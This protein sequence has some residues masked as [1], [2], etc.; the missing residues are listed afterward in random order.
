MKVIQSSMEGT[1]S[2]ISSFIAHFFWQPPDI[3]HL[4]DFFLRLARPFPMNGKFYSNCFVHFE[5]SSPID[6][7][8]RYDPMLDIPPY[9]IPNSYWHKIWQEEHPE[10]W[11][12]VSQA[13]K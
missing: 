2:H 11:R 4:I 6:E 1:L 5:I 12:A 8:S 7:E 3:S 13:S 9:I 10:G